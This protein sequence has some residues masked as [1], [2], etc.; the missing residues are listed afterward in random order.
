MIWDENWERDS[1][2]RSILQDNSLYVEL[3][4]FINNRKNIFKTYFNQKCNQA[5]YRGAFPEQTLSRMS[6][7]LVPLWS[8]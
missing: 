8:T 1:G 3:M 5:G 7:A 2:S 6:F 4:E